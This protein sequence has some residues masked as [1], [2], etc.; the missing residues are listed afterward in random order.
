MPH[1]RKRKN[2]T[3]CTPFLRGE[4]YALD[5]KARCR[6][7]GRSVLSICQEAN[8][9]YETYKSWRSRGRDPN[10]HTLRLIYSV[11]DRYV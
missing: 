6:N 11:L 4:S 1:K 5:I 2:D 9:S 10:L 3:V 8:V 7:V